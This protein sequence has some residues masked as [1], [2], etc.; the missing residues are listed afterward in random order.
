[1]IRFRFN[2]DNPIQTRIIYIYAVSIAFLFLNSVGYYIYMKE[3]LI[4]NTR[5]QLR[6]MSSTV[7]SVMESSQNGDAFVEELIARNLRTA[8]L[9]IQEALPKDVKDI[10]NEDLVIL[11]E[12]AG[13]ADIS[14][15]QDFGEDIIAVRSSK[16]EEMYLSSR[17]WGYWYDAFRELLALK[18][19]TVKEGQT[20]PHYWAGPLEVATVDTRIIQKWGYYYDGTTNYLINPFVEDTDFLK[21]QELTGTERVI[22]NIIKEN[23]ELIKE[24][25]IINPN[26]FGKP[27][28]L[29][30]Q[31]TNGVN[32]MRLVDRPFYYGTYNGQPVPRFKEEAANITYDPTDI[33]YV[34]KATTTKEEAYHIK[35]DGNQSLMK[36]YIPIMYHSRPYVIEITS[37]YTHIQEHLNNQ[38]ITT[39]LVVT[40]FSILSL[41]GILGVSR[42]ITRSKEQAVISTQEI[43]L[44]KVENMF[45]LIKSLNHDRVEHLNTIHS[46]VELGE[47][48][49]LRN[50]VRGLSNTVSEIKEIQ[51]IGNP[52]I[53]AIIQSHNVTAYQQQINFSHEIEDLRDVQNLT[54]QM[55]VDLD[56]ILSNLIKNAFEE[57]R[58]LPADQRFVKVTGKIANGYLQF[59]VFNEGSQISPKDIKNIFMIGF[60]TKNKNSGSGLSI[61]R[62]HLE[63]HQGELLPVVSNS[64]GTTFKFKIPITIRS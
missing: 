53:S 14:L 55:A 43:Y 20:L 51:H 22:R 64:E 34:Q 26:A 24:I 45:A 17:D 39:L 41:F 15:F 8:S 49:E 61:V 7:V 36:V 28:K 4:H 31:P 21:F 29:Y 46:Y 59:E 19:V 3:T 40:V 56:T 10:R 38:L 18:P 33:E 5:E 30:N 60:S 57:V 25:A 11:A 9:Y 44:H 32:L 47:F 58:K 42:F 2:R 12:K 50:F 35:T 62:A 27:P 1:M 48:E 16:P 13:I 52:T 54:G 6:L 23:S 63:K 37:D